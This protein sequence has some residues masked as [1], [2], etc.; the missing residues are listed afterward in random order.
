[1]VSDPELST[2]LHFEVVVAPILFIG[3]FV[4]VTIFVIVQLP[5]KF[6]EGVTTP[7]QPD[8]NIANIKNKTTK[9]TFLFIFKIPP[10][11]F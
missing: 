4:A 2:I 5:V 11:I 10:L 3:L 8:K 6:V 1:M 7:P 9:K